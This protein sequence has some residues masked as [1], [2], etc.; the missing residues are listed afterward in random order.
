D[1]ELLRRLGDVHI[2]VAGEVEHILDAHAEPAGDVDAGLGG[3]NRALAQGLVVA[4]RGVRTLVYVQ[5]N[6]VAEAV[7]KVLAIARAGNHTCRGVVDLDSGR[8]GPGRVYAGL[9]CAQDGVV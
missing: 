6:A 5:A 7:A 1:Y 4:G 3:D 9:L 8:R 2:A